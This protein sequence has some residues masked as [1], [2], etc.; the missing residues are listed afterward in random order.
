M[1]GLTDRAVRSAPAGRHTDGDGLLLVVSPAGR[2]KWVLRYQV[3]GKRRDMGLGTYPSVPL[4]D[5]RSAAA[6]AR[7]Q[8][9]RGLDPIAARNSARQATKAVPTFAEIAATVIVDAQR[10]STNA[11]VRYQ[12]ARHLG[13]VYCGPLLAR[14]VTEITSLDIVKVLR[15]VWDAKPEV[16]RKLYPAIRRVFEHARIRLRDEHGI[17]MAGNP[18]R[19]DDLKAIGFEAPQQL[20]RGHHPSLPHEKL[21]AFVG[22][23]HRRVGIA[24]LALE[25]LILTNVRTDAVLK[26][27]WDDVDI[28]N[29]LWTVP[30]ASLKDRKYRQQGF[31]VPLSDR[32]VE[33]LHAVRELPANPWVF[34]GQ[35]HGKPLSNMALLTLIRRL[36]QSA[37]GEWLDQANGRRITAHG[38]RASFRTWAEE[39]TS[40]PHAVIEEAMGH[41]VG[42]SVER[43]YRRT[44]VLEKRRA[45]M[46]EWSDHVSAQLTTERARA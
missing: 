31:R 28:A 26:A 12:W 30:L 8:I 24:A 18:A 14:P 15:P 34:P 2:R 37:P 32:A 5:A 20:S 35:V 43:A 42:S 19:W 38:F 29:A 22:E 21:P 36:D 4:A 23:L 45:L 39:T 33:I 16:A 13:P 40:Y 10:K 1:G 41:Q 46:R 25:F 9:A 6:E 7:K 3:A 44:D 27:S 11:K 17:E